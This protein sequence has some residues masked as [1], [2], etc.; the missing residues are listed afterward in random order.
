MKTPA[1]ADINKDDS[2]I[3]KLLKSEV[4]SID[5]KGLIN[6]KK[7]ICFGILHCAGTVRDK[8]VVLYTIFQEGGPTKQPAMSAMDKD[9][10]PGLQALIMHSTVNIAKLMQEVGGKHP[11]DLEDRADEIDYKVEELVE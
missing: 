6:V 8:S 2:V 10:S 1:W 7:L 11:M 9:L 3:T 5:G 4:F